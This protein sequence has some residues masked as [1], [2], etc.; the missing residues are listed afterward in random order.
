MTI[1]M[2]GKWMQFKFQSTPDCRFNFAKFSA[3][4]NLFSH[5][6]THLMRFNTLPQRLKKYSM[7]TNSYILRNDVDVKKRLS[8]SNLNIKIKMKSKVMERD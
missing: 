6:S 2:G 7:N 3:E 8:K 1:R 4:I 5:F